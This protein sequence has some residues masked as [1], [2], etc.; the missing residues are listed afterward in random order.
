MDCSGGSFETV[1]SGSF[2]MMSA[3]S[4]FDHVS[5]KQV[6]AKFVLGHE[7]WGKNCTITNSKN[8]KF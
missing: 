2:D 4:S 7:A 3:H 6:L 8:Y 1:G 5:G